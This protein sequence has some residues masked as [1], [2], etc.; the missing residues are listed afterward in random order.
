VTPLQQVDFVERLLLGTLP[1]SDRSQRL[2][3]DAV[4]VAAA[5]C[6]AVVRAKT[7]WARPSGDA[8][9]DI[10]WW[11]GW[12][13]QPREVWM[14]ASVVEGSPDGVRSA[15]RDA[16][17]AVLERLEV[18]SR[19]ACPGAADSGALQP[20]RPIPAMFRG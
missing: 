8:G 5:G 10:G 20:A 12:V 14:F 19:G 4:P 17:L 2:V 7:G 15:R 6:G 16:A 13:E 3:R 11:V 18:V 9:P 1:A